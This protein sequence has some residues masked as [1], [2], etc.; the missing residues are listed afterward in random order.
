MVNMSSREN[1]VTDMVTASYVLCYLDY[2]FCSSLGGLIVDPMLPRSFLWLTNFFWKKNNQSEL[3]LND[4]IFVLIY[5]KI[6]R[7]RLYHTMNEVLL[8]PFWTQ[9]ISTCR[10]PALYLIMW[11]SSIIVKPKNWVGAWMS[12]I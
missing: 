9:P 1:L 3:E 6:S 2:C 7:N 4:R 10:R 5:S 8:T 12:W 11:S